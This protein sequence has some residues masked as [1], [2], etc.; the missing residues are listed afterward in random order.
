MKILSR[1]GKVKKQSGFTLIEVIVVLVLVSI[2]AV[3]A[4]GGFF[5][6]IEGYL[7]AKENVVISQKAQL[8]MARIR[9]EMNE[10]MSVEAAGGTSIRF[11]TPGG[12]STI[13]L[14]GNAVK[15]AGEGI[16]L[17]DGAILIDGVNSL[18]LTYI[19]D[20]GGAWT[21]ADDIKELSQIRIDL[22]VNHETS[23]AGTVDFSTTVNPRNSGLSSGP[24]G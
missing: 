21:P 2:L 11:T 8:A 15:L 22:A 13:G 19:S 10:I 12:S 6:G 3:I 9:L 17:T 1:S 18:S 16:Q 20:T 4:G 14:D 7:F 23:S 5:R 24:I